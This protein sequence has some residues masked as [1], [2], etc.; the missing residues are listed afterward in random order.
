MAASETGEKDRK[1]GRIWSWVVMVGTITA[2]I[3]FAMISISLVTD[4]LIDL[5]IQNMAIL[6]R[7]DAD[8]IESIIG[9]YNMVQEGITAEIRKTEHLNQQKQEE[10][11]D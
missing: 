4:R 5:G 3:A 10:Y 11:Y 2:V 1:K 9:K 7:H 6:S 8:A